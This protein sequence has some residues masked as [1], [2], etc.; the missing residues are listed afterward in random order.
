MSIS[1]ELPMGDIAVVISSCD[2]YSDLWQPFFTLFFRYWSDCP[3]KI[4]LIANHLRYVDP[5]VTSITTGDDRDWSSSF[6]KAICDI[7]ARYLI[8]LLE[9]YFLFSKVDT[10]KIV[11]Y[12]QYMMAKNAAFLQ[13]YSI[14]LH[15]DPSDDH[16]EIGPRNKGALY[17]ISTQPAIWDKQALDMLFQD[18]ESIWEFETKGT[19]RSNSLDMLF[20][21]LKLGVKSPIPVCNATYR[22]KLVRSVIRL[23]RGENVPIDL[24][25]R[26][27][28]SLKEELYYIAYNCW[29]DFYLRHASTIASVK[30]W[31]NQHVIARRKF[32]MQ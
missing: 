30:H 15:A 22:G 25:A 2:K 32:F 7:Q 19:V 26:A 5:R 14:F 24:N 12:A 4:Y 16:P 23:C 27:H 29:G 18:G 21:G 20:L 10:D 8:V 1:K 11:E 9:D 28:R 6:R 13:L 17:R 31:V 3:F